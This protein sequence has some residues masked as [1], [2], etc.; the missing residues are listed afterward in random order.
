MPSTKTSSASANGSS[1]PRVGESVLLEGIERVIAR[2]GSTTAAAIAE[3]QQW[4]ALEVKGEDASEGGIRG[5][6]IKILRTGAEAVVP[7][8]QIP[9]YM[10]ED[11]IRE[12]ELVFERL[13]TSEEAAKIRA[14]MQSAHL[15]SDMES[16]KAANPHATIEDFVRWHSPRDWIEDPTAELGGRLSA[17]MLEPSNLWLETWKIARRIP[18]CRQKPLF[19][20]EKEVERALMYLESLHPLQ[21][22]QQLVPTFVLIV[23]DRVVSHAV[24]KKLAIFPKKLQHVASLITSM[25]WKDVSHEYDGPISLVLDELRELEELA[26]LG[27]AL[28]RQL[29]MQY[30]LVNRLLEHGVANVADGKERETVYDLLLEELGQPPR[31]SSREFVLTTTVQRTAHASRALPQRMY[32]LLKDGDFRVLE[33]VA[34]DTRSM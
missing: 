4:A 3:D 7:E 19:D 5:A 28:L 23:Y 16:F 1:P 33:T 11:M 27:S 34:A 26:G 8:V 29:P 14:R 17:R 20:H 9:G 30:D 12:Q 2:S 6:G 32:A 31:P 15:K 18:A 22:I 10:T 13:G 24:T 25:S 21:I